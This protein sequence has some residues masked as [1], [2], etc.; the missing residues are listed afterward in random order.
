LGKA[1]LFRPCPAKPLPSTIIYKMH[2]RC[3][4]TS[5]SHHFSSLLSQPPCSR[6]P[7]L[8][9]LPSA[10]AFFS[11][12][13]LEPP[14]RVVPNRRFTRES[15]SSLLDEVRMQKSHARAMSASV[16]QAGDAGF[17]EFCFGFHDFRRELLD[18][19]RPAT[20]KAHCSSLRC[21]ALC[22]FSPPPCAESPV[23]EALRWMV[24]VA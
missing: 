21:S 11:F 4:N 3:F 9:F 14:C 22:C 1:S 2:P 12:G 18:S 5:P 13:A 16:Y 24:R 7:H 6:S 8:S 15:F 23:C 20:A 17:V 19:L 10:E